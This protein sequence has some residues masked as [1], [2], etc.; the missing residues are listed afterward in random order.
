MSTCPKIASFLYA[1]CRPDKYVCQ[2]RLGWIQHGWIG[3]NRPWPEIGTDRYPSIL[4]DLFSVFHVEKQIRS[5]LQHGIRENI[6]WRLF[7]GTDEF[8]FS[9]AAV[10]IRR[11]I[12]VPFVH[13]RMESPNANHIEILLIHTFM[14]KYG[15]SFIELR[16][17][18]NNR[19]V[20]CIIVVHTSSNTR[21]A[22]S[23]NFE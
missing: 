8:L 4:A 20:Y 9:N 11:S 1:F 6:C 2:L 13:E 10:V 16:V 23:D 18:Y 3:F 12:K 21:C 19:G 22:R 14:H 15:C 17:P 7:G 5:C